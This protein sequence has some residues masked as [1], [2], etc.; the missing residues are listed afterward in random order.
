[1]LS[2]PRVFFTMAEDGLLFSRLAS[3]HRVFRTPYTA[4]LLA[5]GLGIVL[6]ASQTFETLTNAF[7][8]AIWP[9]YALSVAALYRLRRLH[10]DRPRPYEVAGYPVVPA[11]FILA[12]VWF[13]GNA[14]VTE[15]VMTAVTF[16]LVLA[17]LPVY[18]VMVRTAS[19]TGSRRPLR[20]RR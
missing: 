4:I 16:G 7:V 20:S 5:A 13:V 10:P 14:L 9:F 15:P 18:E 3:V 12:V 6:V 17:G 8:L 2:S 19:A 11:I 1:M